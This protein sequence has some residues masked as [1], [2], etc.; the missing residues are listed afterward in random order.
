MKIKK[1][2]LVQ[3]SVAL[4]ASISPIMLTG[5]GGAHQDR[6][7]SE[8]SSTGIH[9]AASAVTTPRSAQKS[10]AL[11]P[12]GAMKVPPP[13]AP[14]RYLND[15]DKDHIGDADN[16][17]GH[18]TD[19]DAFLDYKRDDNSSYHDSDD[20]EEFSSYGPQAGPRDLHAIA[21]SVERYYATIARDN[22]TS[23]C[24]QL[25]PLLATATVL[26]DGKLG[27]LYLRGAT[28]CTD[29][30]KRLARHF[31]HELSSPVTVT[32]ATINANHALAELGS[33]TLP[34]SFILLEREHGTWKIAQLFGGKVL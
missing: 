7:A 1:D 34:A 29:I 4:L 6:S 12:T 31:R 33:K 8:P 32:G 14:G 15:G 11:L 24:R 23:A 13:A 20:A 17:N 3:A 28:S 18:D 21:A 5:C 19:E 27:P 2:S 22:D 26:D 10:P 25:V 9:T 30:M 16:D